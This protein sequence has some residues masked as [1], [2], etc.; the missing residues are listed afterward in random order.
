MDEGSTKQKWGAVS[1]EMDLMKEVDEIVHTARNHGVRIYYSRADFIREAIIK[2]LG[3]HQKEQ[4]K[5]TRK[6][7]GEEILV[8]GK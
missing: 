6:K 4:S 3:E 5:L 8:T 2:L 1:I 7:L